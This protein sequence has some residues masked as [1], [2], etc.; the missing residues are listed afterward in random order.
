MNRV[1]ANTEIDFVTQVK[2]NDTSST[3]EKE[4]GYHF[5]LPS[6]PN[7]GYLNI[8]SRRGRT[9]HWS[10][11]LESRGCRY[12]TTRYLMARSCRGPIP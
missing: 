3:P 9:R 4:E 11:V 8:R 1:E 12:E 2:E 6:V 10:L 5:P 7:R